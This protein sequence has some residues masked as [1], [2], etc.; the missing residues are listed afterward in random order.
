MSNNGNY[1]KKKWTNFDRKKINLTNLFIKML[2]NYFPNLMKIQ[3]TLSGYN[4]GL[5][6]Q[7]I[8][9]LRKGQ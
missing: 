8:E 3:K 9:V 6:N 7:T 4:K 2:L 5:L 1:I